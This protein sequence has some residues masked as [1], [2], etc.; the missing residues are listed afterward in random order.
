MTT[1]MLQ[2]IN[3]TNFAAE[4][5]ALVSS[6]GSQ[7]WVVVVKGTY[8]IQESGSLDPHAQ[9]EPVC[10]TPLYS[11]EPGKSSLLRDGEAVV[12][13]PGTDVTVLGTAH[14]PND[15][16]VFALDASV[17]VGTVKKTIRVFGQRFWHRGTF[18]VTISAPDPFV[19][20]PINYEAAYGG[21]DV[22]SGTRESRN[23]IGVGFASSV[24][25]LIGKPLP[26]IEEPAHLI[27]RWNDRPAPAGFG[28]IPPMWAPRIDYAGT[29]DDRWRN[30]K[31]PLL[32]DDYDS[33]H[34]RAAHPDLVTEAPLRGGEEAVLENMTPV[35]PVQ[36][37]LPLVYLIVTTY[38]VTGTLRQQVQLDRVIIESD[39]RKLI[40]VWRSSL[41]C[42][43][44]I[45][46]LLTSVI[47]VKPH[48]RRPPSAV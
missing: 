39:S 25:D 47:D 22:R 43:S 48:M 40:L 44:H 27:T 36:F 19:T 16:P 6:D 28:P 12:E 11:G 29:F 10:L 42:G 41:N 21:I 24:D 45:R 8:L 18:G 35:S 1:L 2:L 23:P 33:R 31:M 26:N 13:H 15:E 3:R 9:Q 14:A 30:S 34:A 37:R 5:A 38:T 4:R 32:P 17:R 46:D 20:Q 7:V